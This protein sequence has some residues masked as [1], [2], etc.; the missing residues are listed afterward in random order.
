MFMI[1]SPAIPLSKT[2]ASDKSSKRLP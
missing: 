1:L 2:Y